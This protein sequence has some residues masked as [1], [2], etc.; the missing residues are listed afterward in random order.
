MIL[1]GNRLSFLT[2][3][4]TLAC[5]AGCGKSSGIEKVVVTGMVTL[6]GQPIPNGE[7]RFIPASGTPGPISGGAIKEGQYVAQGRG[8]VPLGN[9]QVDIRAYR[10]KAKGPGQAGSIDAEGGPAVQYLDAKYN[11]RT[12]LTAE[13]DATTQTK[14]FELTSGK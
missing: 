7:I 12:T 3:T 14:D 5:L 1:F 6:D 8:G 11:E 13:I 4:L 10:V 2:L 9:H